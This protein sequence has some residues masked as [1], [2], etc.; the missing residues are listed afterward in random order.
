MYAVIMRATRATS[1][2]PD[3]NLNI[4]D[5]GVA[6]YQSFKRVNKTFHYL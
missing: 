5:R 6:P 1:E 2:D 4:K 3:T